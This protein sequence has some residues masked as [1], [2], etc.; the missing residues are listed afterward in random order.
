MQKSKYRAFSMSKR[1]REQNKSNE[2]FE[3]ML[4][5]LTIEDILALKLELSYKAAGLPIYGIQLLKVLP[6][7]CRTAV[8]NYAIAVS[9]SRLD[10]LHFLGI[11]KSELLKHAKNEKLFES[12]ENK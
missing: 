8:I 11:Q 7:I 12:E 9:R 2:Y 5:N 1:L 10:V 3:L 4:S 6:Q